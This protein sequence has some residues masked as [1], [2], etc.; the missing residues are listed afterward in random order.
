MQVIEHARTEQVIV[1]TYVH[2]PWDAAVACEW[3]PD[4]CVAFTTFGSW[5]VRSRRGHGRATTDRILVASGGLEYDCRHG[6]GLHDRVLCVTLRQD[7]ELGG[8]LLMPLGSRGHALKRALLGQLRLRDV[9]TVEIDQLGLALLHETRQT[10]QVRQP[11]EATRRLVAR[12]RAE[13]HANYPDPVFDLVADA[14]TV[15]LS[16]TRLVHAFRDVVGVTPHRYLLELRTTRAAWM[17]REST[18]SVTDICFAVGFGSLG[19]FHAA[20]RSAFGLTPT[21]YRAR[22]DPA[23]TR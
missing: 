2:D 19:R 3:W 7:V 20:F 12:L 4:S 16:R 11:T 1:E 6:T 9:D 22:T 23:G 15:G 10:E 8:P 18:E 13:A 5:T 21:A 17:L 14:A